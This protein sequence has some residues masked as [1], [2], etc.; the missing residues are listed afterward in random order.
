MIHAAERG[1]PKPL[2]GTRDINE[3]AR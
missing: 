2:L 1:A 3:L